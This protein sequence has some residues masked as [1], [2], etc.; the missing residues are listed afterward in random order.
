MLLRLSIRNLEFP[1]LIPGESLRTP[2]TDGFSCTDGFGCTL[3]G[4][5]FTFCGIEASYVF[6]AWL[7]SSVSGSI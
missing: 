5:M 1:V 4:L 3:F 6:S 7:F 2:S